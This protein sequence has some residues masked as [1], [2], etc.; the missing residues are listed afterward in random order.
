MSRLLESSV[1]RAPV[2]EVV[3][4]RRKTGLLIEA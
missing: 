4:L 2:A 3:F 1:D